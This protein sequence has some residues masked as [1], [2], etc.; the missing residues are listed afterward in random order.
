MIEELGTS[1]EAKKT[2]ANHLGIS[3]TTLYRKLKK[4]DEYAGHMQAARNS[5]R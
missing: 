5:D 3:L 4:A 2:I 1:L